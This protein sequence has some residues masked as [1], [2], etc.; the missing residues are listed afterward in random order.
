MDF[1]SFL[2][3]LVTPAALGIVSS[4]VL[5]LVKVAWPELEA[6]WAFVASL[7]VAAAAA[8]LA[9]VVLPY[10]DQISPDILKFWY[11]IVWV[12]Q[13]V[14]YNLFPGKSVFRVRIER[15]RYLAR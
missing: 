2:T 10:M 6:R 4:V 13:Q 15:R 14:W 12:A 11:I 5:Q 9:S 3:W 1:K 7:V 8:A